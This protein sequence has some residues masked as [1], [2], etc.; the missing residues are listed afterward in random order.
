VGRGSNRDRPPVYSSQ[1]LARLTMK[2]HGRAGGCG[3]TTRWVRFCPFRLSCLLGRTE[4]VGVL[5]SPIY[6]PSPIPGSAMLLHLLRGPNAAGRLYRQSVAFWSLAPPKISTTIR[7][8]RRTPNAKRG[9]QNAKRHPSR[10]TCCS[11][12]S[13]T[14][15]IWLGVR[16]ERCSN[17][18]SN[19]P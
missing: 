12:R 8:K 3:A 2:Q 4:I 6:L 19:K 10:S 9:T 15:R 18:S 11:I 16:N 13:V 7:A 17:S 1:G 14:L 5:D